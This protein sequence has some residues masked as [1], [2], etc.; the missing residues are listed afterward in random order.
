MT[1][2]TR[3]V[4]QVAVET[5]QSGHLLES[6]WTEPKINNWIF[7]YFQSKLNCRPFC[8]SSPSPGWA[9]LQTRCVLFC[10]AAGVQTT[11]L[12]SLT[13]PSSFFWFVSQNSHSGSLF[14]LFFSFFY[15]QLQSCCR[16]LFL[17]FYSTIIFS[18]GLGRLPAAAVLHLRPNQRGLENARKSISGSWRMGDIF[19][20]ERTAPLRLVSNTGLSLFCSWQFFQR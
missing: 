1:S 8:C 12:S 10:A 11:R 20:F 5:T 17:F 13:R 4:Q 6:L 16:F 2:V 19:G 14:F 3:V 15:Q 9:A 18:L 7:F